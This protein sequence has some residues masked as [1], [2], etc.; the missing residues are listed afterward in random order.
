[1]SAFKQMLSQAWMYI[2][3]S[4]YVKTATG[5]YIDKIAFVLS[6]FPF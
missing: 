5:K 4:G 2:D 1:M 3:E 6:A